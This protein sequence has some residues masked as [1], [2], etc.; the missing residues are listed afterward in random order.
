MEYGN[1]WLK[2]ARWWR[3]NDLICFRDEQDLTFY[4]LR[5]A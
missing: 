2:D 5:W 1:S 4:L 3:L